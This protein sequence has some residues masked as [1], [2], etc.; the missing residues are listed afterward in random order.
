MHRLFT[1]PK[2]ASSR[3]FVA[4]GSLTSP[5]G[6]LALSLG[7]FI[8]FA[9]H[10]WYIFTQTPEAQAEAGGLAQKIFYFHVPAAY[11]LYI[12]G[13]VCFIASCAYLVRPTHNKN[14]W[15][16]A[17][18]EAAVAF[19]LM[20]MTSGPLWAKKAWG[21]YWT[22]DPRLTTLLLSV[23]LYIAMVVLRKFTGDGDAERRFAA[24]FGILGTALLPI[25]H[26]SVRL[27]GG[28][29]PTVVGKGG[30]GLASPEMR[31]AFFFG[32]VT[33][34]ALSVL[35]LFVRAR[36]ALI[37]SRLRQAEELS[38]ALGLSEGEL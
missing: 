19:G 2:P 37:E 13:A 8:G 14:A 10:L 6:A 16:Q 7:T 4:L 27:W 28:N 35:L 24:A 15:A 11:G 33:M 21:V 9:Y 22:W 18:A 1:S 29:H 31:H 36:L 23:M 5:S 25:I 17:G 30:G 38:A 12:C 32:F 3:G 26:Y 20:V 34:T